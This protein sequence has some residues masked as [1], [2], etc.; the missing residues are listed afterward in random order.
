MTKSGVLSALPIVFLLLLAAPVLAC[1][2][3]DRS[4][5]TV[6]GSCVSP[7]A[8]RVVVKNTG[9]PM[10]GPVPYEFATIVRDP[11]TKIETRAVIESGSVEALA[12]GDSVV[13]TSPPAPGV[14]IEFVVW[15]RPGHNGTG[16]A[17]ATASCGVN[18]V[19]LSGFAAEPVAPSVLGLPLWSSSVAGSG[20]VSPW[21]SS[22]PPFLADGAPG[23]LA[24]PAARQWASV[25]WRTL[26]RFGRV[27]PSP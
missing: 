11:V 13:L 5:L 16:V 10:A 3:W 14:K 2:E 23:I 6:S 25:V 18:A 27:V 26:L 22:S 4:S 17:K 24:Q 15:Q 20:Q 19:T 9:Q 1:D 21:L 12:A 7:G 8:L